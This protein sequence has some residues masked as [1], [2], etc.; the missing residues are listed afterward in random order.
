[1]ICTRERANVSNAM[2]CVASTASVVDDFG[3][4]LTGGNPNVSGIR[5]VNAETRL[6]PE[7][8]TF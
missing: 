7:P 2:K 5:S 6:H 8:N 4:V 3:A 1:M